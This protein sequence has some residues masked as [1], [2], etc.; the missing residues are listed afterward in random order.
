MYSFGNIIK[1]LR[2]R[3]RLTCYLKKNIKTSVF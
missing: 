1:L 3:S 2:V